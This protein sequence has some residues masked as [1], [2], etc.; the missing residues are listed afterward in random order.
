MDQQL[1]TNLV[2]VG[3]VYLL[4]FLPRF[5]QWPVDYGGSFS[6]RPSGYIN[7]LTF[8]FFSLTYL[9][10]F[11]FLGFALSQ[12]PNIHQY[13]PLIFGPGGQGQPID[14]TLLN[15]NFAIAVVM[16]VTALSIPIVDRAD[17]HWRRSTPATR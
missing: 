2:V 14:L 8:L 5:N 16:L 17:S 10:T 9:A 12:V 6:G 7:D 15:S 3:L 13:F 1:I 11:I 4:V